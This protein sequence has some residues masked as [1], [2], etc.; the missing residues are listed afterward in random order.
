MQFTV[1]NN[2]IVYD[3]ADENRSEVAQIKNLQEY[4]NPLVFANTGFKFATRSDKMLSNGSGTLGSEKS[5][6][7]HLSKGVYRSFSE[8]DLNLVQLI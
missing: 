4:R 8:M 2:A 1:A 7:E 6:P 5:R 3:L